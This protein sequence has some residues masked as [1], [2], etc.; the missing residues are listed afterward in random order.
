MRPPSAAR[1]VF[2]IA[3]SAAA[4]LASFE[5]EA[6]SA[7]AS[8]S[9]DAVSSP[10]SPN[11]A[12]AFP[13]LFRDSISVDAATTSGDRAEAAVAAPRSLRRTDTEPRL[14]GRAATVLFGVWRI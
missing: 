8:T 1:R 7:V 9:R 11:P 5:D 2:A 12:D 6:L 14:P 13:D 10:D 4:L 3:A